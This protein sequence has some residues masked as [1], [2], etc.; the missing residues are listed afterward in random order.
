MALL[1]ISLAMTA[2]TSLCALQLVEIE[3]S[4]IKQYSKYTDQING[5]AGL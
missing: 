2:I 4:K 1:I 5:F 3:N